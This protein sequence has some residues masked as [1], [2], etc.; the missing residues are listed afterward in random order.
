MWRKYFDMCSN[1]V[2]KMQEKYSY[3]LFSC[4][5]YGLVVRIPGSH[6]GGL[7]LIPGIGNHFV[8]IVK[9]FSFNYL[10]KKHISAE[11]LFFYA[12]TRLPELSPELGRPLLRLN[13]W[14]P[15]LEELTCKLSR[16]NH[17]DQERP[18]LMSTKEL[19]LSLYFKKFTEFSQGKRSRRKRVL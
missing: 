14:N 12:D 2:F 19:S 9:L 5:R 6:P 11:C 8:A 13:W 17:R 1:Y 15:D 10:C 16:H 4:L 18:A 7:G 3:A